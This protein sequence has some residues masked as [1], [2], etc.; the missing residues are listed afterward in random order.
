MYSQVVVNAQA[1]AV[2]MVSDFRRI[3]SV[4]KAI[5]LVTKPWPPIN[6]PNRPTG[7]SLKK[8]GQSRP[9]NM[10]SGNTAVTPTFGTSTSWPIRISTATLAIMYACVRS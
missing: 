1:G 10:S 2:P 7:K 4:E 6:L 8:K 5:R 9:T 3:V